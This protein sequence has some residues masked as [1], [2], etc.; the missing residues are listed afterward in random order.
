M[1]RRAA[2]SHLVDAARLSLLGLRV[3]IGRPLPAFASSLLLWLD[4]LS[5]E[6]GR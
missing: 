5:A 1:T 4:K 3:R 2:L 6:R